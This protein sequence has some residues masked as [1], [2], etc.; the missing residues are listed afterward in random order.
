MNDV[1]RKAY[2][3]RNEWKVSRSRVA[4]LL[5]AKS[6]SG[7]AISSDWVFWNS[8]KSTQNVTQHELPTE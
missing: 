5:V 3:R 6:R 7:W 2:F 4:A 1:Q 8:Q